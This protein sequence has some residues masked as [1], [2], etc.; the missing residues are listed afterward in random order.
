MNATACGLRSAR[1]AITVMLRF[2]LLLALLLAAAS[3]AD[4]VLAVP[5]PQGL[6]T[7]LTLTL[8]PE[9][10]HA[11]QA[12]LR[13]FEQ[14][15]GSQLAVLI[16]ASTQPESV[17]QY[18][19]RV[20]EQWKLGRK[21]VDDGALLLVAKN[22]RTV[23]IEVGYGLE[24][25]LTDALSHRIINETIVPAFRQGDYFGGLERALDQ[26]IRL[27][28]GEPLPA[29]KAPAST[30]PDDL[31]YWLPV[32]LGIAVVVGGVMRALLGRLPGAA[33]AA[34]A[35]GLI[36][37]FMS[38]ALLIAL[39]GALIGFL[40]ALFGG[41]L[42]RLGSGYGGGG[43]NSRSGGVGG[44]GGFGGGGASGKW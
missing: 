25:A 13:A 6:V 16:V 12:R 9:Q 26:M 5:Q 35:V 15:K 11:L 40:V 33:L 14:R 36:V 18:A 10:R 31:N 2:G 41:G 32:L 39:F 4:A 23:R 34:A 27:I 44:G 37:W 43:G 42:G 24:G 29:A 22:D 30:E 7:D 8:A 20:A 21:K 28:D 17:E 1:N 19:L 3:A 38:G